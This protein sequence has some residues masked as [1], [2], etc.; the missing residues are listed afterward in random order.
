MGG[1]RVTHDGNDKLL[2]NLKRVGHLEDLSSDGRITLNKGK[3]KKAKLSLCC[4]FN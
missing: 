2:H 1:T 4:F 3:G